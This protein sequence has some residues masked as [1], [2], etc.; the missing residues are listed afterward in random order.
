MRVQKTPLQKLIHFV[1]Y[2]L[3]GYA[4]Q[5][6][7]RYSAVACK[8]IGRSNQKIIRTPRQEERLVWLG[9]RLAALDGRGIIYTL[10]VQD[11]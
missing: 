11:A 5:R 7:S 10:T 6:G 4:G 1:L 9:E 3:V 2:A 8:R